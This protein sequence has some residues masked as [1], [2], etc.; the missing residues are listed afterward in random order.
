MGNAMRLFLC[1]GETPDGGAQRAMRAAHCLDTVFVCAAPPIPRAAKKT[2][3]SEKNGHT[4]EDILQTPA[5]RG[6]VS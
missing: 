1:P 3:H 6:S 5:V 4:P 2:P